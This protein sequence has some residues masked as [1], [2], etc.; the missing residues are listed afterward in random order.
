MVFFSREKFFMI[1]KWPQKSHPITFFLQPLGEKTIIAFFTVPV[2][3]L[4]CFHWQKLKT[5][6]IFFVQS[7]K[8]F[9]SFFSVDKKKSC[10][11]FQVSE[12]QIHVFFS[13]KIYFFFR[14]Q[15]KIYLFFFS[16]KKTDIDKKFMSF[17]SYKWK[18]EHAL[19]L[20]ICLGTF[21]KI[22]YSFKRILQ[23]FLRF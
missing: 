14:R 12:K 18:N 8:K 19:L 10:I 21:Y 15:Q 3:K 1:N 4:S 7:K 5:I 17:F 9:I 20:L 2:S 11:F 16:I 22:I 6:D 23:A 13:V